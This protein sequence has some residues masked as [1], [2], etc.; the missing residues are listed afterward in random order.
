MYDYYQLILSEFTA[1]TNENQNN[2]NID[3]T[4][5]FTKMFNINDYKLVSLLKQN[6]VLGQM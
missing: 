1:D 4:T 5:T 3:P 2:A 6:L